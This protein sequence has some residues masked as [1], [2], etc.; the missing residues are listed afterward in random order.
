MTLRDFEFLFFGIAAELDDLHTIAECGLDRVQH[1]RGRDEHD[2]RK[3]E[4]NAE[5]VIPERVV[6]LRIQNFEKCR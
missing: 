1:V 3:I 4:R 5:I 2:I 6:L